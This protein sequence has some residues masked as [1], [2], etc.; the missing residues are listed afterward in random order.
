MEFYRCI[1]IYDDFTW[2]HVIK[3]EHLGFL[4]GQEAT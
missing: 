4:E 1:Y 2:F 3:R